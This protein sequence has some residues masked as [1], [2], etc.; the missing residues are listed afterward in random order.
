MTLASRSNNTLHNHIGVF[1]SC[2][3]MPSTSP[4]YVY[5]SVT[6]FCTGTSPFECSGGYCPSLSSGKVDFN[7]LFNFCKKSIMKIR[8]RISS[9]VQVS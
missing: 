6:P 1:I 8:K 4:L 5:L 7:E 2:F 9:M 3:S